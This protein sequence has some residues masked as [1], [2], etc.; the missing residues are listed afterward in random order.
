M[1]T[2]FSDVYVDYWSSS[3]NAVYGTLT[4][5][6][7]RSGNTVYLE[8][9][10][11][12]LTPSQSSWGTSPW[13]FTVA[14]STTSTTISAPP[15]TVAL[16]S[17][18]IS[19]SSTQTS[20]SVSWYGPENSGSFTITFPANVTAPT[21]L[22]VSNVTRYIDGFSATV[23]I[24][25]WGGA[26]DA[27]TRY[28]ELQV[29]T[30]DPDEL[31]QPRR[32]QT[33]VGNAL[34]STIRVNNSSQSTLNI[35]PNTQYILGAYAT[36]GTL[37]TGSVRIGGYTTLPSVPSF[38]LASTGSDYAVVSYT[39]PSDGGVFDKALQYSIQGGTT[40]FTATTISGGAAASGEFT[41][42]NLTPGVNYTLRLRTSTNAGVSV[43]ETSI[44]FQV[45]AFNGLCSVG[46]EAVKF[47]SALGSVNG[48][49]TKIQNGLGSISGIATK[50]K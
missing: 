28:R 4:G 21:G 34:S 10:S 16:N 17:A 24:T 50:I 9:M 2:F 46:G 40:W 19:V 38:D 49:A 43:S 33:T 15:T 23:S 18:S 31:V 44:V 35:Q 29:W 7:R 6:V 47:T 37:N 45:G 3:A 1:A 27:N 32:F 5:D 22:S 25:G 11:I 39:V 13:S 8:N 42:T 30:Y 48:V 14:G 36:N 26:G 20:A 12:A 41:I